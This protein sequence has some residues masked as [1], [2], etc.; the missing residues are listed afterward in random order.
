VNKAIFL[1]RDGVINKN[2]HYVNCIE[3][4]HILPKVKDALQLLEQAGYKIFV[5]TNQGGIEKGFLTHL[6]LHEIHDEML[7]YLPEINDIIYCPDYNSFNRKPNPGMI[8]GLALDY[9]IATGKSWMI[10]D[11]ATDIQAGENAGCKTALVVNNIQESFKCKPNIIGD[12]LYQVTVMILE[13]EG[14]L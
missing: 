14:Y 13:N 3:N 4:F 12:S 1:D 11:M 7:K 2:T 5:V 9:Q 10:G 8:L 6:D